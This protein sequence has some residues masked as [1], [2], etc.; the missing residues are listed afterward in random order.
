MP[1]ALWSSTAC[2]LPWVPLLKDHHSELS[3][4]VMEAF[5]RLMILCSDHDEYEAIEVAGGQ[6]IIGTAMHAH[7]R[8]Q[9]VQ[10]YGGELL[11]MLRA[12]PTE[13]AREI[14]FS[15]FDAEKQDESINNMWHQSHR[16]LR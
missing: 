8:N 16:Q 2:V 7:G 12:D 1:I 10:T 14:D 9:F 15:S 5:R 6:P 11:A 13:R 4:L 3:H